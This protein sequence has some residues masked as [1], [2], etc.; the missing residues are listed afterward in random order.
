LRGDMQEGVL[1]ILPVDMVEGVLERE[2][3]TCVW[4]GG[5]IEKLIR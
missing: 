1:H 3:V 5:N 2:A 4:W